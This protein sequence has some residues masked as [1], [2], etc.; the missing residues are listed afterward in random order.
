MWGGFLF[1]ELE[2]PFPLIF[3]V[4]LHVRLRTLQIHQ[5]PCWLSSLPH[6]ATDAIELQQPPGSTAL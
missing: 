2:V 6:G 5:P 3:R 1:L 4:F